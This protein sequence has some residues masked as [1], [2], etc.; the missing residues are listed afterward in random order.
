MLQSQVAAGPG[1]EQGV[2][3]RSV[4]GEQ[5]ADRDAEAGIVSHRRAQK[6]RCR[7]AFL[8]AMDGRAG[9]AGVVVDGHMHVV[10][11]QPAGAPAEI[12]MDAMAGRGE[13]AQLLD[14]QMEQ[15][16]GS[17]VFIA[18]GRQAGFQIAHTAEPA[19]T[20]DAADRS[21]AQSGR[22]SDMASGPALE[23]QKQDP[24]H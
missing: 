19:A 12:A 17:L 14:I 18:P 5:A 22:L 15:V 4:V 21:P 23:P 2:I 3:G 24:F 9:D 10:P 11:A 6:I 13:A 7:S 16:P 1:E 8:V 20:E